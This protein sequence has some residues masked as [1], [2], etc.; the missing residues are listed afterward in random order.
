[1][2]MEPGKSIA[3]VGALLLIIGSFV[4][5]LGIVG[6]ILIMVGLKY[7]SDYY[8]DKNIFNN[9]LYGIIFGIIGVAAAAFLIIALIFGGSFLGIGYAPGGDITGNLFAFFGGILI[10]LV[11]AFIFYILMALYLKKAFDSLADR[12][13]IGMFRTAGMLLL[14]GA[15]LTIILIGLILIFV[16]WILLTIAFFSMSSSPQSPP[17][18]TAPT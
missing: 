14:I 16:A 4:P 9:A 3:G 1:M 2:S 12:A 8:R 17:A 18:Q 13:G 10:T 7:L 5:F 6:L 15:I 11:V